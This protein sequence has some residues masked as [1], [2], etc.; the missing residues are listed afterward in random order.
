VVSSPAVL[1]IPLCVPLISLN[2]ENRQIQSSTRVFQMV[3]EQFIELKDSMGSLWA[4]SQH[5]LDIQCKDLE[6]LAF[7][8]CSKMFIRDFLARKLQ[9][10][11]LWAS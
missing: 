3:S 9:N 1:L 2:A 7:M 10:T 8:K 6:S 11:R 5:G 4:G